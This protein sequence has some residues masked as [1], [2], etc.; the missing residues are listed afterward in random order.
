LTKVVDENTIKIETIDGSGK[1]NMTIIRC[2]EVSP[3]NTQIK[4]QGELHYRLLEK[5]LSGSIMAI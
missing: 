1:R 2:Q 3:G 4:L 5:L